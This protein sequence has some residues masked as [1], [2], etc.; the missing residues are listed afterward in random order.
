MSRENIY[1]DRDDA[2]K[3]RRAADLLAGRTPEPEPEEKVVE[4]DSPWADDD[5][6]ARIARARV[7]VDEIFNSEQPKPAPEASQEEPLDIDQVQSAK[8]A[9]ELKEQ[10]L[11][12][13]ARRDADKRASE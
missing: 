1:P 8:R 12:D 9:T 11:A 13:K 2:K 7:E 4:D 5:D 10:F 6:R 3:L